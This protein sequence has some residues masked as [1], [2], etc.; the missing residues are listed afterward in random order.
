MIS[1]EV[2][3]ETIDSIEKQYEHDNKCL[4]AASLI[5]EDAFEGNLFYRNSWLQNALITLLQIEFNDEK[6]QS[7]IDY[8]LWELD[9]GKKNNVMQAYREDGSEIKLTNASELY[10]CLVEFKDEE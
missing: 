3:I 8:Y 10:D 4:E 6:A 9:F 1:K 5:Y 2:F 7:W